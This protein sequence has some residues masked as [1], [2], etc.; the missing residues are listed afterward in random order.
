MTRAAWILALTLLATIGCSDATVGP[1]SLP[2]TASR[3]RAVGGLVFVPEAAFDCTARYAPHDCG[4]YCRHW[5]HR[6]C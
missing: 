5:S 1:T 4:R 6:G 3:P 2:D